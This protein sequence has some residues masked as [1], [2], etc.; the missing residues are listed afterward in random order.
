MSE[1]L[2]FDLTKVKA[3]YVYLAET[4]KGPHGDQIQHFDCRLVQPNTGNVIPTGGLHTIEHSLASLLRDHLTG[5]IDNSPFGSRTG[6][7]LILWGDHSVPE[8]TKALI[9]CLKEIADQF[10]WKDVPAHTK[11]DC[12]NYRDHSLFCA[13][14]WIKQILQQGISTDPFVKKLLKN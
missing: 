3:P 6:F 12:G 5:Y 4:Q 7:H 9:A 2:S 8:V 14:E 10:T 13:K 1:K 11:Y